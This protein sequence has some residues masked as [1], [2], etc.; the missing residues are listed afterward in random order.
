MNKQI[1]NYDDTF[2]ETHFSDD[3]IIAMYLSAH[4]RSPYTYRNYKNAIGQFR[5]FIGMKRLRD[6]TWRDVEAF[7]LGLY[8]GVCG[9]SGKP[10]SS[11]TIAG[12]IAPL[13]SLYKWGSDANIGLFPGNPT[14]CIRSPKV[15]VT[16]KN[17]YLTKDELTELLA[18]LKKISFRDYLL[19][20]TLVMLGLRV[21]E[22]VQIKTGDFHK[23]PAGISTW[24]TVVKGKGGKSREVKVPPVLG[25]LLQKYMDKEGKT[26]LDARVF[27]L[28]GRQVERIIQRARENA[29][30]KKKVTP[31]WLRHTNATMALLFGASIQQVQD[32][33]GHAQ[34]NTTQRYLHTVDL[35]KKAASDFV[36]DGIIDI[37]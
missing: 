10:K 22:V 12:Y 21:S 30:L 13:R 32:H 19:G 6:V 5:L 11:A 33:L 35:L 31:H 2:L 29:R 26:M 1:V 3:Q 28:T 8:R 17:H 25:Q 18:Q 37:I 4:D 20:L 23:D 16:S 34:I 24:L 14:S 27:P 15:D 7:K 36:E 9:G